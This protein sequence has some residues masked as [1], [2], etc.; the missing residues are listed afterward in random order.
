MGIVEKIKNWGASEDWL[1]VDKFA[2]AKGLPRPGKVWG[3]SRIY[4][5]LP[6][7]SVQV[8]RGRNVPFQA[9]GRLAAEAERLGTTPGELAEELGFVEQSPSSLPARIGSKVAEL[10]HLGHSQK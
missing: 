8:I 7:E 10:M 5:R 1:I 3:G 6:P 9:V 4:H 2:K